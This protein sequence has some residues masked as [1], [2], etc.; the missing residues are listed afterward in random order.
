MDL[1]FNP[2]VFSLSLYFRSNRLFS[3]GRYVPV[4]TLWRLTSSELFGK[5][6]LKRGGS[7][8]Q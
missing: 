1:D 3:V 4:M 5:K 7:P 6:E 2:S 8:S